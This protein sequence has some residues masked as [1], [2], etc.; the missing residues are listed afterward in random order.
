MKV[1][2]YRP[3]RFRPLPHLCFILVLIGGVSLEAQNARQPTPNVFLTGGPLWMYNGFTTTSAGESVQGSDVSPLKTSLGAGVEV[4]LTAVISV[5]PEGWLFMQEYI[6]LKAYPKTVPTQI[7][8][9]AAVGDIA[10]TLGVGLSLPLT[11]SWQSTRLDRW[12]IGARGG[13][14]L[15]FRIPLS[16]IDGTDPGAVGRYWITGRFVYPQVGIA[17]DY[18]LNDDVLIGAVCDWLIPLYNSWDSDVSTPFLDETMIR[19][20]V[21]LRLTKSE[22]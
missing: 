3:E 15:V 19:A 7:E 18:R 17:M 11:F 13:V 12:S 10:S 21:R 2:T 20:G 9:G 6:A 8:T 1:T 4:P 5:E 22:R 16:G 14:G